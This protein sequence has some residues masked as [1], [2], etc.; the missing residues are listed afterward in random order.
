MFGNHH[1]KELFRN[2]SFLNNGLSRGIPNW[3]N[4]LDYRGLNDYLHYYCGGS[5]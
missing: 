4:V 3:A 1:K 5:L 2:P